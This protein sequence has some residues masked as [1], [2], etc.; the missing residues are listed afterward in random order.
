MGKAIAKLATTYPKTITIITGI[1]TLILIFL[2]ALPT[3]WPYTFKML[4]TI[5]VDTDPENMLSANEPV[6]IFHNEKKREMALHDIVVVGVVNHTHPQGVFNPASL[7]NVYE[8][9]EYAKTLRWPDSEKQGSYVGVIGVDIIAP[10]T[11]DNIEQETPGTVSFEWLMPSPPKS[12]AEAEAVRT[13]A[14]KIPILNG[15]LVSEDG[16][17]LCLYL[18]ITSKNQS[19]RIYTKLKEKIATL[20]GEDE[21]LITGLPVANDTFGVEMF[22]Q[23]GISAPL[24]MLIIFI[25]LFIFFQKTCSHCFSADSRLHCNAMDH[26]R[27]RDNR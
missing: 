18:P 14:K 8:L 11:V 5:K 20:D 2:A 17:A 15:T 4:N 12:Q 10:S 21:F 3:L 25:T 6:R 26:V 13:K 24:A 7:K 22:V 9:T 19:Y 27:P 16:K 23:M 1:I